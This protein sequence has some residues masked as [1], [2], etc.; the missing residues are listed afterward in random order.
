MMMTE[1][2]IGALERK[3]RGGGR[4]RREEKKVTEGRQGGNERKEDRA[5]QRHRKKPRERSTQRAPLSGSLPHIPFP[6][7]CI[8]LRYFRSSIT[9]L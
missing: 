4:E 1:F 2:R 9:K 5:R 7:L 3:A 8:T 6:M